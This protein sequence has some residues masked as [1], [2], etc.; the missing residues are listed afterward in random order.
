MISE[1][2]F[3]LSLFT[4]ASSAFCSGYFAAARKEEGDNVK[5]KG[6]NRDNVDDY[7]YKTLRLFLTSFVV[8]HL[9]QAAKELEFAFG[10]ES[11]NVL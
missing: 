4:V 7:K 2:T 3:L 9:F 5:E 8:G 10:C 1:T 11:L 6:D